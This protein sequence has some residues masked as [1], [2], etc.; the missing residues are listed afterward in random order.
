MDPREPCHPDGHRPTK[1]QRWFSGR[2]VQIKLC[3]NIDS[4]WIRTWPTCPSTGPIKP[5]AWPGRAVAKVP[6]FQYVAEWEREK[7]GLILVPTAIQT[8]AVPLSH[9][10]GSQDGRY[11]IK[12]CTNIDSSWIRIL[13]LLRS[14]LSLSGSPFLVRFLRICPFLN[15]TIEVVTFRLR[16]WCMLGVFSFTRLGHECQDL[17]SPCDGMHMCTD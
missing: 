14:Q 12:L 3:T 17:L 8:D 4:S 13:L 15:P 6:V 1:P 9:R 16:G 7:R 2:Q 5:G 11:N 10:G